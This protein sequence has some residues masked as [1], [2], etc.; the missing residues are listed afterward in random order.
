MCTIFGARRQLNLTLC[1]RFH[2]DDDDDDECD[3]DVPNHYRRRCYCF[4]TAV[5]KAL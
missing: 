5:V 3:D 1:T 2:Y 4:L